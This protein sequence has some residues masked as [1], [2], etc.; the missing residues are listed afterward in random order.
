LRL[1]AGKHYVRVNGDSDE[2]NDIDASL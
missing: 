2:V 1:D